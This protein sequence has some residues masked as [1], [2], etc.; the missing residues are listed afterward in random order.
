M[1][2]LYP[3][4]LE[5]APELRRSPSGVLLCVVFL[6]RPLAL[7]GPELGTG[8]IGSVGGAGGWLSAGAGP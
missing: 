6:L 2:A 1:V 5:E 4:Y 8:T 7:V 3:R